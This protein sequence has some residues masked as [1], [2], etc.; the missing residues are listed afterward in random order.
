MTKINFFSLFILGA[1]YIV[2]IP[3]EYSNQMLGKAGP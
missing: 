2:D 1:E 3:N